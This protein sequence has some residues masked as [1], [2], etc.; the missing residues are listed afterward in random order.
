MT[1]KEAMKPKS[2]WAHAEGKSLIAL[3]AEMIADHHCLR[4]EAVFDWAK[5]HCLDLYDRLVENPRA[6]MPPDWRVLEAIMNNRPLADQ[7]SSR[8]VIPM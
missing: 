5:E 2:G 8:S 1:Y 4:P 7:S 3:A 6:L